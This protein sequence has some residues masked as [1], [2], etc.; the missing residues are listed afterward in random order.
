MTFVE[1][2]ELYPPCLVRLL[3]QRRA[4]PLKVYEIESVNLS[5]FQVEAISQQTDWRGCTVYD[6]QA[7]V[8][9]C[10]FDFCST[11]ANN[12]MDAYIRSRPTFEYLRNSSDWATYYLPLLA[13]WR[14]SREL[15]AV[16]WK[17]MRELLARL[18]V[19]KVNQVIK[20]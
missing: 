20:P 18:P 9:G 19:V 11:S 5:Q 17:P 1:R 16:G 6:L 15:N 12:R 3:A 7:F 4:K 14:R 2:I 13:R 8:K 10:G